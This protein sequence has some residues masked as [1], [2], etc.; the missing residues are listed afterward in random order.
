M[1]KCLDSLSQL[2][3]YS[4]TAC[5]TLFNNL[6]TEFEL[7]IEFE[8]DIESNFNTNLNSNSKNESI[9]DKKESPLY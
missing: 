7:D 4:S 6:D 3:A 1:N 5:R 2:S 8:P 9:A